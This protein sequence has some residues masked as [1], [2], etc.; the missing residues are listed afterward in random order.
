[1]HEA[2]DPILVV[3]K[4]DFRKMI[5]LAKEWFIYLRSHEAI[6]GHYVDE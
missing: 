6:P 1:L 4:G 5:D 3:S 2:F